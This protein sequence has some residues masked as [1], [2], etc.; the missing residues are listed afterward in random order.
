MTLD[1]LLKK[2]NGSWDGDRAL[3]VADGGYYWCVATGTPTSYTLTADGKRFMG[4]QVKIAQPPK[5]EPAVEQ[6]AYTSTDVVVSEPPKRA[7]RHGF[8]QAASVAPDSLDD[9]DI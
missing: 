2:H 1:E 3:I 8:R 4:T 7:K 6:V 9:L 5:I